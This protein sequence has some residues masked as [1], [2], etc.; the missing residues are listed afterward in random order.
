M[1]ALY[2]AI[3]ADV[4]IL[5]N[6]PHLVDEIALGIRHA[7]MTAHACDKFSRD[8][9]LAQHVEAVTTSTTSIVA[10]ITSAPFVRFRDIA[11]VQVED[12]EQAALDYPEV[13]LVQVGDIYEPNYPGVKRPA[14]AWLA[15]SNLN[16]YCAGGMYGATVN[17]YQMPALDEASYDSW[18]A[19]AM[20]DVIVWGAAMIVW[21]RSGNE[22]KAKEAYTML[23]GT[24]Q[25]PEVGLLNVLKMN[26]LTTAGR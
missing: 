21:N 7:T 15:G 23:H 12:V 9:V 11:Q 5:T 16:I 4:A 6:Q 20:P 17:Y 22:P 10:D 13:E 24:M 14:T 25:N 2:S 19:S 18:I 3:A 26:C 8:L 1:T